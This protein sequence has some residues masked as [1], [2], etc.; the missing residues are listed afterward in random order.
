MLDEKFL[1]AERNKLPYP[2]DF[3]EAH[4]PQFFVDD[5][6]ESHARSNCDSLQLLLLDPFD[7]SYLHPSHLNH[8]R[9]G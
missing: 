4:L 5:R 6:A 1:G 8:G 2:L 3:G 7:I 9:Y